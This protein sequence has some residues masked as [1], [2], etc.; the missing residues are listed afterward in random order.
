MNT[1]AIRT[2]LNLAA[3]EAITRRHE[4]LTLE[5]S[6]RNGQ[7]ANAIRFRVTD[8]AGLPVAG[9]VP[10]ISAGEGGGS[11]AGRGDYGAVI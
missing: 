10:E 5:Q 6:V 3:N 2:T 1:E 11:D 4:F 9:I 8:A 7:L